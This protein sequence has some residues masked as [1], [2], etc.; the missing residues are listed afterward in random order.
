M[1][2]VD[3]WEFGTF[4]LA[5]PPPC[6]ETPRD[7]RTLGERI[8]AQTAVNPK[9][10]CM[11]WTG[12]IQPNGYAKV[13]ANGGP[14]WVHRVA[15]TMANGPIP[16]GLQVCHHCDNPRCLNVAHLFLGTQADNMQDAKAKGRTRNGHPTL[17]PT[18]KRGHV[19]ADNTGY[20]MC[21]G[22]RTPYCLR[23]HADRET[24]RYHARVG[25]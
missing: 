21:R 14:L 8:A 6:R 2:T 20:Q 18:C 15:W 7:A 25:Q 16:D 10:G 11:E 5:A 12:Y 17:G 4:R 1:A 13:Y 19:R 22:K 23:C 9:T 24:M 3:G